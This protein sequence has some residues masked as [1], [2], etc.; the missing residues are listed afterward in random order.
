MGRWTDSLAI[1]SRAPR[2]IT[3]VWHGYVR[4]AEGKVTSFDAPGADTV[5]IG[6]GT[7]PV[8]INDQGVIAGFFFDTSGVSHGYLLFPN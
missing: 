1:V 6:S 7:F 3:D 4:S 2:S 8:S 5:D